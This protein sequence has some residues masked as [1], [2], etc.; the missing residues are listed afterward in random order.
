MPIKTKPI[1]TQQE[2]LQAA[3]KTCDERAGSMGCRIW[4]VLSVLATLPDK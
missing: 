1:T 2:T 4:G 3:G